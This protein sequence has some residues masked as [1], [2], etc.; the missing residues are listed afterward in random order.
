MSD[1]RII[2][3]TSLDESGIEDG[4][5]QMQTLCQKGA[6]VA[7]TAISGVA[8]TLVKI[9]TYSLNVGA[10]FEAAMS[11][12]AAVSG[13]SGDDLEALTEKAK[14]MGAATKF[15]ATESAE[16][17]NYMAMA[18]W[19]TDDMLNGLEGIM[20]LAAAS[21]EDLG[22]TSDIVTDALTAFGLS[23]SDSTHF[24]DV[25]AAAS[26]NANTNVGM[27]GETFKYVA[28]VAGALGFSAEDCAVAIGL[29]ANSGIKSSQAGTSLRSML[30]KLA[31]P[32]ADVSK[33]MSDLGISL[34]NSDGSMKSLNEIMTTMRS[35]F[36]GLSEAE[37]AQYASTLAGQE[38]MSGLL[39]IV[40]ASDS[41]FDKL[42][43]A[44]NSCDGSAASMAETMNDNLSGQ[45]TILQSAAEGF[46]IAVYEKMEGPLRDLCEKGIEWVDG[47]TEALEKDGLTGA[48]EEAGNVIAEMAVYITEQA[49]EM[50]TAAATVLKSFV[51]GIAQHKN[52]L[53]EA[54]GN[55]VKAL[56]DG[57]AE[58][59]PSSMK[60]VVKKAG[61]GIAAGLETIIKNLDKLIPLITGA[62][63]AFLTFKATTSVLSTVTKGIESLA[64]AVAKMG[65]ENAASSLT[66][67]ASKISGLAGP[68]GIAA[69]AL[70]GLGVAITS[71]PTAYERGYS[72]AD[73]F[74]EKQQ[75]IIDKAEDT[76]TALDEQA[77]SMANSFQEISTQYNEATTLAEQLKSVVDENGNIYEGQE[78]NAKNI[79]DQLN[80]LLGLDLQVQDNTIA[81]YQEI[82]NSLDQIIEKKK[83]EAAVN[84]YAE[85]Y[86][87][88]LQNVNTVYNDMIAAKEAVEA[89]DKELQ[90]AEEKLQEIQNEPY[91]ASNYELH[92][93]KVDEAQGSVDALQKEYDKLN[94]AL[95]TNEDAMS[96]NQSIITGYDAL[97][98]AIA[99]GSTEEMST[100]IMNL[101]NN[102]LT[103]ETATRGSLE[104]QLSYYQESYD[105]I[106]ATQSEGLAGV[107]EEQLAQLETLITN[108]QTELDKLPALTGTEATEAANSFLENFSGL[109]SQATATMSMLPASM[110]SAL[111][112]ADMNGQLSSEATAA[113]DSF[114]TAL[115]GLDEESKT[116]MANAVAPMISTLQESNPEIYAAAA[117]NANSLLNAIIEILDIHSP[118]RAVASL[119]QMAAAGATLGL[120]E[121]Q[122]ETEGTATSFAS[123][124]LTKMQA[125]LTG[126]TTSVVSALTSMLT[127]LN[128]GLKNSQLAETASSVAKKLWQGMKTGIT[129]GRSQVQSAAAGLCSVAK[130]AINNAGMYDSAYNVGV[131]FGN[132]LKNGIASKTNEIA[133]QAAQTVRAAI[134][135][136][137]KEQNA[138]SPAKETIKVGHNFGDGAIVGIKDR[139]KDIAKTAGSFISGALDTVQS[140]ALVSRLR[141]AMDAASYRVAGAMML[142]SG[143]TENS[144]IAQE[145]PVYQTININQPVKSPVETS[146]ELRRVARELAF[147]K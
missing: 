126:G 76:K 9:A 46:G 63:S 128:N 118:S 112:E 62:V 7:K 66:G 22:T 1:G 146:R 43:S 35:S 147:A 91:N 59:L 93:Q 129:S 82:M 130:Q 75:D 103:A 141:G 44:I 41:D 79:V 83:A 105:N 114:L 64:S 85:E 36:S 21:G 51:K 116:K 10:S 86:Q 70:V 138:H 127:A 108:T 53:A 100:A 16:A 2:I 135:A 39:A 71:M 106:K 45:F 33:A 17:L 31:S 115:N 119:F 69:A 122:G 68:I 74:T 124:I 73:G 131:N 28:P 133:T 52:Q 132:G 109:G 34:T 104:R 139:E 40:G 47:L 136:A 65:F 12:V 54:A 55:I 72:A 123:S 25:L 142:N 80:S 134:D 58:L 81:N 95:A 145:S 30:N 37:K 13:A 42:T 78:E 15:S 4:L 11:Q 49:P 27:M 111:I 5:S 14:E 125:G 92:K 110:V 120:T 101:S 61:E 143:V 113:K 77:T 97:Q 29:M 94:E 20:N 8:D 60:S 96:R 57:I 32:T 140:S 102:F 87:E 137:N 84:A 50:V 48:A 121:G 99:S 3:D 67:F 107:N 24:A 18:G 26:S 38:A 90:E 117:E 98:S 19:K 144:M 23:A 6:E 56:A 88:A 89:K